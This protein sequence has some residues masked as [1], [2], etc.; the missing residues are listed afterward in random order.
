L[1]SNVARGATALVAA[2]AALYVITRDTFRYFLEQHPAMRDQLLR[3]DRERRQSGSSQA[4]A[5]TL[6]GRVPLFEGLPGLD[7]LGAAAERRTVAPGTALLIQGTPG[8]ELMVVVSGTV[9]IVRGGETIA[10][11]R[12]GALLGEGAV[13]TGEPRSADAVAATRTTLLVLK[14]DVLLAHH[15]IPE[16]L[17]ATRAERARQE[18]RRLVR[19]DR[20]R[21]ISALATVPDA[22]LDAL[23]DA[24]EPVVKRDG[25]RL[26][27]QGDVGDRLYIVQSGN[28]RI[29]RD[30]HVIANVGAGSCF[31]E[32]ALLSHGTRTASAVAEGTTELLALEK[33]VYQEL[34]AGAEA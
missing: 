6:L 15:G 31:G 10:E 9:R 3:L 17:S 27:E 8:D 1:L 4:L 33:G 25:E 29:E 2:D 19:Q 23:A 28:V 26:F 24:L 11:V 7:V 13:L 20:L 22:R 18:R 16:R 30:R 21:T 34:I 5:S 12:D 32:L 14:R